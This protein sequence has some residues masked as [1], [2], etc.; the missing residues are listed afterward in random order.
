M[1]KQTKMNSVVK[2][3]HVRRVKKKKRHK[4]RKF[5]ETRLGF[6]LAHEVPFE[7]QLILNTSRLMKMP[8]PT[9]Q[10]IEA[11]SYASPE[12][13]FRKQK[14]WRCLMDYRKYGL[15]T[16]YIVKTNITKELYYIHIRM[17]KLMKTKNKRLSF[18]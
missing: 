8:Y 12:P 5:S 9:A 14:F 10:L 1:L 18:L 13:F 2:K 11:I 6:M 17:K 16:P 4:K 7:Y 15:N 3:T